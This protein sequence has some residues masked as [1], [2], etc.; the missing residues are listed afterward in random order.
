MIV[1]VVIGGVAVHQAQASRD[2]GG[3]SPSSS[4]TGLAGVWLGSDGS[5][6]KFDES[7]AGSYTQTGR[8]VCGGDTTTVELS[9]SNGT[10]TTT[11]PLYDTSGG[12]CGA[13]IGEVTTT[14]TLGA[15]GDSARLTTEMTSTSDQYEQVQC[16]S[17]GTVTL[18]RKQ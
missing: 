18:T 2:S 1:A 3:S 12:S 14:I 13:V 9:G 6:Y 8:D 5:L 10:Y 16:Y 15:G 4:P 11:G 7:G 17:C